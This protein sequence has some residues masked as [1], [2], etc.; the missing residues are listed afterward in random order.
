MNRKYEFCPH[1]QGIRRMNVSI[2]LKRIGPTDNESDEILMLNYQC[3]SC[4][5]YIRMEPVDE[6]GAI[7]YNAYQWSRSPATVA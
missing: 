6:F 2:S 7:G 1:C 3:D 5:S 4:F